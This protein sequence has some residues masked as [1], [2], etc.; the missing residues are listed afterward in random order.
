MLS[1]LVNAIK[2]NTLVH[3]Y[4]FLG[5]K[6]RVLKEATELAMAVNCL[7]PG[8]KIPCGGCLACRKIRHGNHP[9]V[10]RIEPQGASLKIGQVREV[11]KAIYY[12]GFEGRCKVVILSGADF[13]TT[14]AANSL[15]KVLEDPP[16][17][18]LFILT[19]Q[20]GDNILPTVLSR[21]QLIKIAGD[22]QAGKN[23]NDLQ[24]GLSEVRD[25][26][27]KLPTMDYSELLAAS[28]SWEKNRENVRA[29]LDQLLA[30]LRDTVAAKITADDRLAVLPHW[31]SEAGENSIDPNTALLAAEEVQKSQRQ[32]DQNANL[33]L[34]LDVLFIKLR[35]LMRLEE[36]YG[37]GRWSQV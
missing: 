31:F 22:E 13:L 10:I 28:G 9:D 1:H 25:I 12:K 29:L 5:E 27:A 21:C 4:L 7:M 37:D 20:N 15:L 36:R 24:S 8:G 34:V 17:G 2:T 23:E 19:A 11:Q 26:L 30:Y 35:N 6:T 33:H 14:E 3:A 16:Q 18:T 32:I